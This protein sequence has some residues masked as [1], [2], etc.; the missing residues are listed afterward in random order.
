MKPRLPHP[1]VPPLLPHEWPEAHRPMLKAVHEQGQ[2]YNN[3]GTL[4]RHSSAFERVMAWGQHVMQRSTLGTRER[5][6]LILRTGW[7]CQCQY[8]W[9]QHTVIGRRDAQ[10]ST[11]EID[12]VR[13]GPQ[14]AGWSQE[15]RLLLQAADE[16]HADHFITDATWSG[17]SATRSTEQ[18]MDIIFAT[19]TYAMMSSVMNS[20]GV[21][22]DASFRDEDP[23]AVRSG[24]KFE[25]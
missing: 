19:G 15:D 22:L 16:L 7:L 23:G 10:L 5:E 9:K 21:Q 13:D 2:V 11:A 20:L 14:A 4:A 1:R 25:P 3:I 17:L 18:M 24:L 8:V 12:L 6:L